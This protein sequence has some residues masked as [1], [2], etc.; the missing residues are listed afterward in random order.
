MIA[1][2]VHLA[3]SA[4]LLFVVGRMIS[5]IEVE[6]GSAAI[7]GAI[8]LGVANA[9][10]RPILLTLTLP[11][12]LLTLGLFVFVVNALML[13][14]ASAFVDGF[15]VKGFGAALKGTLALGLLNFLIGMF[16]GG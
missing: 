13:M 14:L 1:F 11:I 3:L 15:E 2:F 6:D 9:I 12:T 4:A 8:M 16:F 5:G 7:F 10:V